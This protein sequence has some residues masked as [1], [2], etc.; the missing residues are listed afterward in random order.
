MDSG[1]TAREQH[2]DASAQP[3]KLGC[4]IAS[5][6][7]GLGMSL[8]ELADRARCSKGYLSTIET[9]QR[10]APPSEGLL[11]RIESALGLEPDALI[12]VAR[13]ERTPSTVRREFGQL[14][15]MLQSR[16]QA[17][18]RLAQ[19]LRPG[20]PGVDAAYRSG[21]LARLLDI[22]SP[23]P[24]GASDARRH[25]D[26]ESGPSL[27]AGVL[28]LASMLPV[29]V[30][31]INAVSAGY[32]TEFTDLGYP[33]RVADEHVR[34]PDVTDPDAFACRVVGDSMEPDYRAGDIVVFSPAISVV[35]GMDCFARLEP[36][37]EST[38]KR[39]YFETDEAGQTLIRLQPLNNRYPP[40][41]L[42][43]ERVAGLYA[44]VRVIRRIQPGQGVWAEGGA[45]HSGRT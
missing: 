38:F 19:L 14:Q 29:D 2:I 37:H 21:E 23:K 18:R 6:R 36:D 43:R 40:R 45:G 5:R 44:A 22:V 13:W 39:A 27:A 24:V 16:A 25:N 9:G 4:A 10:D 20:G 33:A 28:R 12:D 35:S 7:R 26:D 34:C 17:S 1:A 8:S 30:P 15:S 31:V 42:P 41:S 32:P 3:T 11:R